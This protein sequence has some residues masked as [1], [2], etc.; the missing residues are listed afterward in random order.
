MDRRIF[1]IL[2][3]LSMLGVGMAVPVLIAAYISG[4]YYSDKKLLVILTI[5]FGV[6]VSF[7]NTYK[8]IMHE[9][10]QKSDRRENIVGRPKGYEDSDD[11]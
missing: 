4:R 8:I 7:R 3:L 9:V 10:N 6:G 2:S 5:L 11:E 1:R